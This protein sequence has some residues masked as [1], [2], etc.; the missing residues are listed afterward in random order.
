MTFSTLGSICL[1]FSGQ[2]LLKP[3]WRKKL[4]SSFRKQELKKFLLDTSAKS[5]VDNFLYKYMPCFDY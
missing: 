5:L 4:P 3:Y 2:S 1:E